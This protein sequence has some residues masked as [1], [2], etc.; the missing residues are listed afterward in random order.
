MDR[1]QQLQVFVTVAQEQSFAGA[2]RRL[3]LSPPA[4]TRG[5]A[6][7]EAR[8][9]VTLLQRTTRRVRVTRTGQQFLDDARKVLAMAEEAEQAAVG[10]NAE[11][12]GDITVTA[13][14][15]FGRAYVTPHIV[16]FLR[17]H[18]GVNM[19]A[20]FLDRIVNLLEE[21]VDVGVRI[22]ELPDSGLRAVRVGQVRRV[23]VAAPRYLKGAGTP[24]VPA[25][26][27]LHQIIATRTSGT[28]HEWKFSGPQRAVAVRIQP[29]LTVTSNDS[30]I[31]AA[32]SGAGITRLL[33][34]Q[35]AVH[36]KSR[37]LVALLREY[38][39]LP[40]PVHVIH[41]ESRLGAARVR[42]FVD[43]ICAALKQDQALQHDS[44]G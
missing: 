20:V 19:S 2:A 32:L 3:G 15:L 21:G 43:F 38:E 7:L 1:L 9:G 10:I 35:V 28:V 11:L 30:A 25:E 27:A 8:L 37:K 24:T 40:L 34:Y 12:R 33:S 18:P 44:V 23:V 26:L 14:V 39:P 22:G 13:P 31:E 6:G 41:G 5:V 29:R 16:A 4:V 17:R 42:A 36:I